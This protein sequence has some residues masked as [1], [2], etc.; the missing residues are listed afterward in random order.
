MAKK[1]TKKAIGR[2][3][4]R[5]KRR[6]QAVDI[7]QGG[8]ASPEILQHISSSIPVSS[9]RILVPFLNVFPYKRVEVEI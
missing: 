1:K 3:H 9:L 6:N 2:V 8:K 4:I 7:S 5:I